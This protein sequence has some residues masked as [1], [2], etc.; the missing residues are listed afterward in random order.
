MKILFAFF[1]FCIVLFVYLHVQFHLKTSNDLEIYE[2]DDPS[3]DKLE[4]ICDIRQPVI[5]DFEESEKM[6][7]TT[8]RDFLLN[9]YHAFEMKVRNINDVDYNS[10]IYMPLAL[11]SVSKLLNEDK[12][13]SYF[14]ENNNDFLQETGVIK[15]LQYNDQ[16]LRP[17]M[18]SNYNYDIMMAA[19]NTA[20]PFRYEINYRNFFLVTQGSVH[21]KLAPPSSSK[22]L[23]P[24]YDYT[25]F[26]FRTPVNPW[27]VQAKYM[28][29]FDKMKCL[30]VFIEKGK[31]IHIPAYWWYSIKF[32]KES[33]IS[34]F[35]YRTYM[36][37]LAISPYIIMHGLQNQNT[38]VETIKKVDINK[39]SGKTES[40]PEIEKETTNEKSS[41]NPTENKIDL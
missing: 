5:F 7:E 39:F 26:E 29:D 8:N 6:I 12:T 30:D 14:S 27:K 38:K 21:I 31:V 41:E 3:K 17:P 20:T 9:H 11:H 13:S 15:N 33:S 24:V 22:Y 23:Y 16:F 36:N 40:K 10:E 2:I 18:L 28:A 4:E 32:S 19:E 37:N 25:N 1:I 35:H 34:C